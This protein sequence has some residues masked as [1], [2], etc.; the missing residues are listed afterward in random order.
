MTINPI[1]SFAYH[2]KDRK[3]ICIYEN[4]LNFLIEGIDKRNKGFFED[5]FNQAAIEERM[6]RQEFVIDG[7]DKSIK[8]L[9]QRL[10]KSMN[11]NKSG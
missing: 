6:N 9:E 2:L 7:L 3:P 10:I 8:Y 1:K 11:K 4:N 5:L